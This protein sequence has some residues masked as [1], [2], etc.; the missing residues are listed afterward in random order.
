MEVRVYATL[1]LKIGQ[2]RIDVKAGPGDTVRDALGEVLERYP[3]LT[4]DVLTD[5]GELTDHVQVFLNGRNVRLMDGL[6]SVIQEEQKLNI[7]PPVGGG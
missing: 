4:A 1:R 7:F 6:D 3:V 5:E 2:S